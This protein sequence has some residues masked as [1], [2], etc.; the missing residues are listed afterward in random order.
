MEQNRT[1]PKCGVSRE[2]LR[3]FKG[4]SL[5]ENQERRGGAKTGYEGHG[6]HSF[7]EGDGATE[8][9]EPSSDRKYYVPSYQ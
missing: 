2:P 3:E 6:W 7:R 8:R 4:N 5:Q 1:K 9:H